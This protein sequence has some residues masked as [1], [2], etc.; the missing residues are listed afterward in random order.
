MCISRVLFVQITRNHTTR[1]M[2]RIFK[3]VSRKR[4]RNN[5]NFCTIP[6][7]TNSRSNPKSYFILVPFPAH[8]HLQRR[9]AVIFH[10][11][12]VTG[13]YALISKL[14]AP[15]LWSPA[16]NVLPVSS[17]FLACNSA[18]HWLIW[19]TWPEELQSREQGV[20]HFRRV[21]STSGRV[22]PLSGVEMTLCRLH[23]QFTSWRTKSTFVVLPWQLLLST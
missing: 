17:P 9:L 2:T 4:L 19:Y 7:S 22:F 21:T 10:I 20:R 14:S 12:P 15:T 13:V 11:T 16:H 18:C 23:W 6:E 8:R 5:N 3:K 1:M